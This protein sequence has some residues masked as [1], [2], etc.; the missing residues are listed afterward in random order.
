MQLTTWQ[1]LRTRAYLFA[2]GTHRRMTL[3]V[4][5]MLIDG[6]RVF[7]IRHSY[8]PGWHL[9]GGGVE[10]GETAAAAGA[11]ELFEETG[12]APVGDMPLFGLFHQ[13]N[14]VTNRDHVALYTCREFSVRRPFRASFEIVAGDWFDIRALPDDTADAAA[15]RIGEVLG[16]DLPSPHW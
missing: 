1:K 4:R 10:P 14:S 11:R 9:P 15:R 8:L 2:V 7:L 6:Q 5:V 3:G 12:Y 16:G 13:D